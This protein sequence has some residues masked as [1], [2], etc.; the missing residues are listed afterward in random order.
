MK[1]TEL[2]NAAFVLSREGIVPTHGLM[3]CDF[4]LAKYLYEEL[5]KDIAEKNKI[6]SRM[7]I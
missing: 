3:D 7:R 2:L 1:V 5:L 4:V 6:K